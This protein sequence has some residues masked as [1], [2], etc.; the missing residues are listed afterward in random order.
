MANPRRTHS[1]TKNILQSG[2]TPSVRQWFRPTWRR[3][4][5]RRPPGWAAAPGLSQQACTRPFRRVRGLGV[6]VALAH[7][8][9]E[10]GLDMGARAAKPVVKVEMAEGGV[11]VVP[12]EQA[13]HPAAEPDAFR[14]AG[15]AGQQARGFG[16]LV[17]LLLAFLGGFGGRF[18]SSGWPGRRFGRTR[19]W[20][21]TLRASHAKRSAQLTQQD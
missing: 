18:L 2:Q 4:A 7:Q 1:A 21:S 20:R 16:D 6:D 9:A 10:S 8:A 11:E 14:V 17:D 15:R 3:A 5:W 12:P 13:D 19:R